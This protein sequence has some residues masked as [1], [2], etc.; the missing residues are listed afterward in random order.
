VDENV[1]AGQ[2]LTVNFNTLKGG[3]NV[4][5]NGSAETDGSFFFYGGGGID[6]LTGGAGNDSFFFGT[7]ANGDSLFGGQDQVHGGAGTQDQLG[8]RGNYNLAFGP[9]QLT[10]IE[11]LSLLSGKDT[12]FGPAGPE[13]DYSI[14]MHDN[15]VAAGQVFSVNANTLREGETLVFNGG[16]EL[17]GS[18]II[19]SGKGADSL[20]GGAGADT[21]YGNT[22]ADELYGRGGNDVFV[23]RDVSDSTSSARDQIMDFTL[24]DLIDLSAIDADINQAGNQ[25][26][27]FITG[28]FTN[29]AGQ[30]RVVQNGNAAVIFGDIDGDGTADF[31]LNALVTDGHIL[32]ANDFTV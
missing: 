3:E 18:F 26:F 25:A 15:N 22:G 1:G 32:T 11:T 14:T 10:G 21:I 8:L 2:L 27:T 6:T 30:L 24:G 20:S 31:V 12:R 9:G 16:S 28:G 23:Y 4:T 5:F 13:Y 19:R 7:A 17:D 29:V